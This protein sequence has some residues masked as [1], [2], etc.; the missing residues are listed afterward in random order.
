MTELD[1]SKHVTRIIDG[2]YP[3]KGKRL[4]ARMAADGVYVKLEKERWTSAYFIPWMAI[5]SVGG[6]LKAQE[7]KAQRKLKRSKYESYS[8]S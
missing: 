5:Y 6:K 8:A 1:F 7:I 4:I 2:V 3:R